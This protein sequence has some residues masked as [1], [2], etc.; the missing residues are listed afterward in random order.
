[1]NNYEIFI[2]LST[3]GIYSY[4]PRPRGYNYNCEVYS[5]L[6]IQYIY[7]QFICQD[8]ELTVEEVYNE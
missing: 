2:V 5:D 3:Y 4:I 7:Q 6:D 8:E 1:M